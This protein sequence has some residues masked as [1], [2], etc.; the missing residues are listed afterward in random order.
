MKYLSKALATLAVLATLLSFKSEAIEI[1]LTKDPKSAKEKIVFD[2]LDDALDFNDSSAIQINAYRGDWHTERLITELDNKK[3]IGV[4]DPFG[5][6]AAVLYKTISLY[7]NSELSNMKFET[8][9]GDIYD[10]VIIFSKNGKIENIT[11]SG[12]YI[13]GNGIG[14]GTGTSCIAL[15][16]YPDS[17]SNMTIEGNTIEN[18]GGRGILIAFDIAEGTPYIIGNTIRGCKKGIRAYGMARMFLGDENTTGNNAFIRNDYNIELKELPKER[19]S[20]ELNFWTNKN[21]DAQITEK[22]ILDTFNIDQATTTPEGAADTT[23]I[24]STASA[25]RTASTARTTYIQADLD[26]SDYI[27]TMPCLTYNPNLKPSGVMPDG[28]TLYE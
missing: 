4:N 26:K 2:N 16:S 23:Y 15:C 10:R 7:S 17:L 14:I 25:A 13:K 1:G 18:E 5:D 20:A 12:N 3:L 19:I 22:G 28:W 9:D 24:S 21:G 27:D 11:V 8:V 6:D